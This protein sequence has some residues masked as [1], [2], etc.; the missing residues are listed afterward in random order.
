MGAKCYPRGLGLAAVIFLII[1][2]TCARYV[3]YHL[4]DFRNLVNQT[5][6]IVEAFLPRFPFPPVY[7]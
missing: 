6:D 3:R 4:P 7:S 1:R 5:S 2:S